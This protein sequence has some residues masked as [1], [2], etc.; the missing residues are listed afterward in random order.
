VCL[1]PD[2]SSKTL[3]EP[4]LVTRQV[5]AIKCLGVCKVLFDAGFGWRVGDEAR[6][7]AAGKLRCAAGNAM[8]T[9]SQ[10][11]RRGACCHDRRQL[12]QRVNFRAE[13]IRCGVRRSGSD[14]LTLS[15]AR[16]SDLSSSASWRTRSS[17]RSR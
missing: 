10:M 13:R 12:N 3:I 4:G 7:E 17:S 9:A 15:D 8:N 2:I 5:I 11:E 1:S 16:N 6:A 14:A